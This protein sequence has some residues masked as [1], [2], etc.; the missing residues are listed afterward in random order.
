MVY[1]NHLELTVDDLFIEVPVLSS[2][3]RA[4]PETEIIA[5]DRLGSKT[6]PP[7]GSCTYW[8]ELSR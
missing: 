6:F 8:Q 4:P 3:A 1:E 5:V 7:P 2:S